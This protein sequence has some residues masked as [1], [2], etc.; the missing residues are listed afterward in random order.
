MRLPGGNLRL[1]RLRMKRIR[2]SQRILARINQALFNHP[3]D[4]GIP[5]Q[6]LQW[7]LSLIAQKQNLRLSN[8]HLDRAL[9]QLFF[10]LRSTWRHIRVPSIKFHQSLY[11]FHFYNSPLLLQPRCRRCATF[12]ILGT[13]GSL[14]RR[15]AFT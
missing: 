4:E 9:L 14:N 12:R 8:A 3:V 6:S 2:K 7:R 13:R 1:H 11:F 5:G 15:H 10:Q